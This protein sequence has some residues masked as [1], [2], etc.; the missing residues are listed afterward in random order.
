MDELRNP[1]GG[2]IPSKR[3]I[4]VFSAANKRGEPVIVIS[5]VDDSGEIVS[6]LCLM[7]SPDYA[8]EVGLLL[9]DEADRAEDGEFSAPWLRGEAREGNRE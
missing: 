7:A 3:G 9:I 4:S 5:I 2:D 1:V 8:R 6:N